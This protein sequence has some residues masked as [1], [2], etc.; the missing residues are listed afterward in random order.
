MGKQLA[1]RVPVFSS[2]VRHMRSFVKGLL[3]PK[4]MRCHGLHRKTEQA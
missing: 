1:C 2:I 3:Q 4:A